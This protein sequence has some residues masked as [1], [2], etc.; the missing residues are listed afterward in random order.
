M[1]RIA[2]SKFINN[3]F[4]FLNKLDLYSDVMSY[5]Y[6]VLNLINK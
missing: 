4:N 5:K 3:N 6:S 2:I 1:E